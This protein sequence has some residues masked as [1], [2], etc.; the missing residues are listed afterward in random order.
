M[1]SRHWKKLTHSAT[2]C[3]QTVILQNGSFV[4]TKSLG[5]A[6]TFRGVVHDPGVIGKQAMI[7]IERISILR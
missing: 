7:L 2:C 3:K 4:I 1:F 6:I 5:D